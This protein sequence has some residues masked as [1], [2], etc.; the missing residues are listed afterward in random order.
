[1][2]NNNNNNWFVVFSLFFVAP[3]VCEEQRQAASRIVI[4]SVCL[5]VDLSRFPFDYYNSHRWTI[6]L[7]WCQSPVSLTIIRS[8]SQ[9]KPPNLTPY[10]FN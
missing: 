10:L 8:S 4:N 3:S 1:M 6:D 5:C 2:D 7:I 9:R